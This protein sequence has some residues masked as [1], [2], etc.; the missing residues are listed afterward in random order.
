M[1]WLSAS[2]ICRCQLHEAA[3]A[4][5]AGTGEAFTFTSLAAC[6][7][8]SILCQSGGNCSFHGR[9]M[10]FSGPGLLT[11]GRSVLGRV[12]CAQVAARGAHQ[13]TA[14]CHERAFHVSGFMLPD[15]GGHGCRTMPEQ[16]S[17]VL[18]PMPAEDSRVS[19]ASTGRAG[20]ESES[21]AGRC[22]GVHLPESLKAPIRG[23]T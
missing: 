10:R 12:R 9:A 19:F 5:E 18:E 16:R 11:R 2:W 17:A 13:G 4:A 21:L 15:P 8:S 3:E 1:R 23:C 14:T 7:K 6:A 20:R 22:P